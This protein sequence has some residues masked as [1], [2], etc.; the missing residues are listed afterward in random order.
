MTAADGGERRRQTVV[1]V[2][3]KRINWCKVRIIVVRRYKIE[4]KKI[5]M[6]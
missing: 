1:K 5:R 4:R 6:T 3:G 2:N